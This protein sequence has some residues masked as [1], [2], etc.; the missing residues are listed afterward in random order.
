M[1]NFGTNWKVW[2]CLARALYDNIAE[3]PDELA[4]RKGDILVVLEQNTGNIEGWWLCS[5]RG[6]Q[7]WRSSTFILYVVYDQCDKT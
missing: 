7:L 5:L 4:F 6:R 1:L 2:N 3:S